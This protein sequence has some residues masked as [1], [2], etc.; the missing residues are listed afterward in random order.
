M[1]Y[2]YIPQSLNLTHELA[3]C[4][5]SVEGT[6]K[7]T[8][9]GPAGPGTFWSVPS[10]ETGL[11]KIMADPD[12]GEIRGMCSAGP[13]GGL[14]AGYMAFLMQRNFSVHDFEEFIEVHPST[15]GVYGLA[16]YTSELLRKRGQ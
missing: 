10:G 15:D 14:I 9:P 12:S 11:A 6:A 5:G 13:G 16:K 4:I 1:D 3:F 8:V 2:R 7:L